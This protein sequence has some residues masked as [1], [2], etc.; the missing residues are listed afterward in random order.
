[1]FLDSDSWVIFLFLDGQ[2]IEL[3]DQSEDKWGTSDIIEIV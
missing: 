2:E 3:F 1:M